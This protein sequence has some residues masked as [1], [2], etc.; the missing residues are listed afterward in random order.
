MNPSSSGVGPGIWE[1]LYGVRV[2]LVLVNCT[3]LLAMVLSIVS[4][5]ALSQGGSQHDP[6]RL[7]VLAAIVVAA[8]VVGV[9]WRWMEPPVFLLGRVSLCTFTLIV[10]ATA[11]GFV[12]HE[13]GSAN[14]L[15]PPPL[16]P[17]AQL[18]GIR[19]LL[20]ERAALG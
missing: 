2:A 1:R 10:I 15:P 20:L 19:R 9:L 6:Y 16:A 4:S 17:G 11:F 14:A 12:Y 5:D 13:L 18:G 7:H 8:L 3:L